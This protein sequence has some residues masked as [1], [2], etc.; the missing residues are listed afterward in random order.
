MGFKHYVLNISL[1]FSAEGP[2]GGRQHVPNGLADAREGSLCS[3]ENVLLI[4][5]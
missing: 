1:Y 2:Y 5:Q 4:G 3:E